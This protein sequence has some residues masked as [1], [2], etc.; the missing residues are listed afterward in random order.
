LERLMTHTLAD[1][2]YIGASHE[3]QT[4]NSHEI[5]LVNN[6]KLFSKTAI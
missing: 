1:D 2:I 3:P 4:R 6:R 5:N